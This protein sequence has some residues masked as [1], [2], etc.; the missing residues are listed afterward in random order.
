M[1]FDPILI[2]L[3]ATVVTLL[4]LAKK[5]QTL[6]DSDY[7]F[8]M[9]IDATTSNALLCLAL[10]HKDLLQKTGFIGEVVWWMMITISGT[11]MILSFVAAI[12]L[13]DAVIERVKR[14][15]KEKADDSAVD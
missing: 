5:I 9:A 7:P 14:E 2:P 15:Q 6:N 3:F 4:P 12:T 8:R 13:D 1:A 10:Q 11:M